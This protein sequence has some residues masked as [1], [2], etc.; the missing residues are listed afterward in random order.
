MSPDAASSD[1]RRL[2]ADRGDAGHRLDHALVRH[3]KN[4][5]EISRTTI[6]SWIEAGLV[7]VNG[8][9]VKRPA[10]RLRAGDVIEL[11]LPPPPPRPAIVPEAM[12]LEVVYEDE[13]LLAVAKPPGL[14]VH[15][16]YRNR[17]GTLLNALLWR[18]RQDDPEGGY[19]GLVHRLDKD[20]SGLL[21]VARTPAAHAGLARTIERRELGKEYLALVYG[22]TPVA[23]G[24][25]ELGIHRDP[26]DRRR[27]LASREE[28]RA[29]TTRYERLAESVG[30][31]ERLTLLRVELVTGR[32]HQIRA[33]LQAVGLPIVG[34]PV[35]GAPRFQGIA[36][37]EL[38]RRCEAFPR[39]ALHAWRLRLAHPATGD[40]L[41]LRAPLPSDMAELLRVVRWDDPRR[42]EI[43][44]LSMGG[45]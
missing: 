11:E 23:K 12:P 45:A 27:M 40:P 36:D 3:L 30:E 37:P 14:V 42:A 41:E 6:Q 9:V 17:E 10:E 24:Q 20:T 32:T 18:A 31:G 38:S 35:Y 21:L 44:R 15:P 43:S 25:I 34:D 2:R 29:S 33:H 16:A 22:R 39:Q 26:H 5:A 19:V 1:P 28:G 7:R 4:R 8:E 13:H